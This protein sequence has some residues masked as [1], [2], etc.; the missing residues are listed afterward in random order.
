MQA[1]RASVVFLDGGLED[2]RAPAGDVDLCSVRN[3]S[4]RMVSIPYVATLRTQ[5]YYVRSLGNHQPNSSPAACDDCCDM[6]DIE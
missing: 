4:P 5:S 2:L 3:E 6:R 1:A